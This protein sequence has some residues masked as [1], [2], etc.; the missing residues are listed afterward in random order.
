M[1]SKD[2]RDRNQDDDEETAETSG[3]KTEKEEK[4]KDHA[5]PLN[6]LRSPKDIIINEWRAVLTEFIATTLF[7]FIGLGSV[8]ASNKSINDNSEG[9][10]LVTIS[11]CFGLGLS[12]MISVSAPISGGQLNPA[13]TFGLCVI[14]QIELFKAILF[15]IAQILGGILAAALALAV[16]PDRNAEAVKLGLTTLAAG[17]SVGNGVGIEIILTFI[18]VFTACSTAELPEDSHHV[19]RFAPLA[20][21]F[22]VVCC[23]M[24]GVPFTGTGINPAR[25]FGPAVVS[26]YWANH[27]VYWVGPLIGAVLATVIYDFLY[28]RSRKIGKKIH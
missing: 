2:R 11:F 26:N 16:Y 3:D 9:S 28:I 14:K 23:N 13:L 18:F 7:I 6:W 5:P 20:I 21:G 10:A 17:V 12:A 8:I 25:T 27:W 19:R 4:D 22:A 15:I 24:I 1:S